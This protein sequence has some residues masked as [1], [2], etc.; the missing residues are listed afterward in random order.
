MAVVQMKPRSEAGGHGQWAGVGIG[1]CYMPGRQV[2]PEHEVAMMNLA[3]P[4]GMKRAVLACTINGI[5]K[6]RTL[7]LRAAI[8]HNLEYVLFVDDDVVPPAVALCNLFYTMQQNPDCGAVSAVQVSKETPPQ[9]LVWVRENAGPHW[10]WKLGD[11]FPVY[12]APAGCLLVR[13]ATV[14]QIPEPWF[15]VGQDSGGHYG[16]DFYFCRKLADAGFPVLMDGGIVCSHLGADGTV[17]D[18]PPDSYPLKDVGM[19]RDHAIGGKA[20]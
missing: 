7:I 14:R 11:V 6:A 8:E 3:V 10:K 19:S 1:L 12:Y 4:V 16:E 2:W 20:Q 17:Y 18:L 5:C 13:M 9:P 15:Q